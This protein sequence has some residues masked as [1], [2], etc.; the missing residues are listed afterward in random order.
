MTGEDLLPAQVR[1]PQAAPHAGGAFRFLLN[2]SACLDEHMLQFKFLGILMG[3][4]IRTKKPLDLHLAPLVWKQLCCIPLQLE[5]LEEVD[6]LYVQT[7]KSILHIEDS[8]IT[9]DNFHE[10]RSRGR[11]GGG[12]SA[13]RGSPTPPLREAP[14]PAVLTRP[15]SLSQMI[16][17]DSF[18]GQSADGKMVPIIPGGNSIP[19]SF[20]NR[21]EYVERAVEYRLHEIDRQVGA[22]PPPPPEELPPLNRWI[23]KKTCWGLWSEWRP[24]QVT[25]DVQT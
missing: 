15:V 9:E 22:A 6:L 25:S 16:P 7:L 19:L 13:P 4:A 2:P 18:V 11:S 23:L 8:G 14:P 3:V 1:L 17:L 24:Q 12:S 10:V 5:D 20:S 21:K